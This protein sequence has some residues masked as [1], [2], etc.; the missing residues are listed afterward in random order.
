VV[1][2]ALFVTTGD[3]LTVTTIL[4]G[5][6]MHDPVVEVAVTRYSTVP[7]VVLLRLLSI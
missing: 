1:A 4:C 7:E 3:G 6:P 2:E 5:D